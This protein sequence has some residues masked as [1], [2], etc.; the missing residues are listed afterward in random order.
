MTFTAS[1][2]GAF[3]ATGVPNL[4]VVLGGGIPEG[5][6][7]LAPVGCTTLLTT[8]VVPDMGQNTAPEF[9]ICDG[10]VQMSERDVGSQH[11]R[12][13][14]VWKMRGT[15][16]LLGQQTFQITSEGVTLFP[17]AEARITSE[18]VKVEPGLLSSGGAELDEMLGGGFPRGSVSIVAGAPGTGK[19]L[20]GL[21]YLAD[22]LRR[23]EHGLFLGFRESIPQLVQK[24]RAFHLDIASAVEAG[25]LKIIRRAPVELNVDQLTAELIALLETR[26]VQRLVIDTI[27][28]IEQ[29]I[30]DARRRSNV[31]ASL[32]ELLRARGTTAL[33]MHE[34]SQLAGS[35]VD[36]VQSPLE[37]LAENLIVLRYVERGAQLSRTDREV[38]RGPLRRGVSERELVNQRC[39]PRPGRAREQVEGILGNAAPHDVVEPGDTC[40]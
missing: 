33:L 5:N 35:E 32:L 7:Q 14:R 38:K 23:G 39:L 31:M 11:V 22:G 12:S 20:L 4:D 3:V 37:L 36:F 13:L 40:G 6:L 8:S 16:N 29:S 9:A 21:Q 24:A 25:A 27:G 30:V 18:P 15:R 26:P 1:S 19:T 2:P 34:V 28:E 10:I 17:R